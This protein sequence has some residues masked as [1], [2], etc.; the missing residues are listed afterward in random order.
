MNGQPPMTVALSME[1]KAVFAVPPSWPKKKREA[2]FQGAPHIIAPD[3][4]NILKLVCD[5]LSGIV[6]FDDRIIAT[7]TVR[8]IYGTIPHTKIH[9]REIG[10]ARSGFNLAHILQTLDDAEAR[11]RASIEA[12]S[13]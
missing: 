3:A 1:V 11:G 5:A 8:K 7:V 10:E 6:F 12:A 2:A 9:I 4:D 13:T